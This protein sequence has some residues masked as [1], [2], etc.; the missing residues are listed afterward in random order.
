MEKVVKALVVTLLVLGTVGVANAGWTTTVYTTTVQSNVAL[1]QSYQ[2]GS[3][4]VGYQYPVHW[5]HL[6]TAPAIGGAVTAVEFQ[7]ADLTV[8]AAN[9]NDKTATIH[10]GSA[11]A[12]SLG[13]LQ[14][15]ANLFDADAYGSLMDGSLTVY[16]KLFE[17]PEYGTITL[18]SS[19][20]DVVYKVTECKF[21][22]D[23]APVVPAPAAIILGSLGT[24]LVGWLRRRGT[25]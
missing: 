18:N 16:A 14:S 3:N 7:S 8:T 6:W 13:D 11:G 17:S 21:V 25:V 4:G 23:P 20:L 24:G 19:K 9:A 12:A 2:W 22:P 5:D 10:L 15:G 1:G